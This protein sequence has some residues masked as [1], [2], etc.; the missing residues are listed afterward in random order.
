[1]PT[2]IFWGLIQGLTEFLPISSSGHLVLVPAL[3][4]QEGPD[5]ATSAV[6]HLGTLAAVIAYYRRDIV[7]IL[8]FD[9]PGRRLLTLIAIGTIPAVIGGLAFR[10][11]LEELNETPEAVAVALIAT[12]VVLLSTMLVRVGDETVADIGPSDAGIIGVAQ[13]TALIPG[14]SR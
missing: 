12:G 9:R 5:L 6:L 4:G 2:A 10:A 8:R 1:M 7:M 11:V 13:A 14:V 3:L